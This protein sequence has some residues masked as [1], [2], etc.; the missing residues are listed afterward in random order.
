MDTYRTTLRRAAMVAAA[1]A[2]LVTS[3]AIAGSGAGGIFNLGVENTVSTTGSSVGTT[4]L[5]GAVNGNSLSLQNTS[6]SSVARAVAALSRSASAATAMFENTGGGP[7]LSLVVPAGR[8]PL[9]VSSTARVANLNADR[10]DG[11]D[12][13]SLARGTGV[14]T[15]ANR[16][17]TATGPASAP[18]LDVPGIGRLSVRCTAPVGSTPGET[19]VSWTSAT[20][21]DVWTDR[22]PNLAAAR[23]DPG[24]TVTVASYTLSGTGAGQRGSRVDVGLGDPASEH[25]TRVV[26]IEVRTYRPFADAYCVSQAVATVWR[27]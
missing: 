5:L 25:P 24:E 23:L 22:S 27:Q 9:A 3:T 2:L 17:L 15:L 4:K 12:S 8:P 10:I 6:T 21:Q 14:T 11:V 7:A 13:T 20:G 19:S 18:L 26:S 1:G 16:T